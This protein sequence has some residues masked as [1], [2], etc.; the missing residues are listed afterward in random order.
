MAFK[1]LNFTLA[2]FFQ[3]CSGVVIDSAT[4]RLKQKLYGLRLDMEAF[5]PS[6]TERTLVVLGPP[7]KNVKGKKD[8][9]VGLCTIYTVCSSTYARNCVSFTILHLRQQMLFIQNENTS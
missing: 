7:N 2:L 3:T 4:S 1:V 9:E 8:K 6:K 5:V